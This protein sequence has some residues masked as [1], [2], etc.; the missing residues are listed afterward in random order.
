MWALSDFCLSDCLGILQGDIS[1]G[2]IAAPVIFPAKTDRNMGTIA[3]PKQRAEWELED[4][5]I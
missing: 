1:Q 4:G 3:L 5:L 2:S